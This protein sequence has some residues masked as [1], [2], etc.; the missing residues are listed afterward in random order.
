VNRNMKRGLTSVV[1]VAG[2]VLPLAPAY[3]AP[4]D[5]PR[6]G[7]SRPMLGV[8]GSQAGRDGRG[9]SPR[10]PRDPREPGRVEQAPVAGSSWQSRM[11]SC[12]PWSVRPI[13]NSAP[14]TQRI[15]L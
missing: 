3:A 11:K 6:G 1:V 14:F 9:Q 13:S 2:V 15:A 12:P 4:H 5:G 7:Q 10:G 8:E